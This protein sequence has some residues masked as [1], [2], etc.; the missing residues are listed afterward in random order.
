MGYIFWL[1]VSIIFYI[2]IGYP[3]VL[4]MANLT[5]QITKK[6]NI[7]PHVTLFIPAHNEQKVI[8]EKIE[9]SLALDYPKDKFEV[10]VASDGSGDSTASI[11]KDFIERGVILFETKERRGKNSIINEFIR[12][13][14]GEIIVFTDANSFFRADAIK[15][16]VRNFGDKGTGCVV[17]NLR[18]VD[19]KTSVGQ[20]EGLYF[21]YE[22][23]IK[24]LESHFGT[25][26]AATGSIYAIRKTLFTLL[27]WD[28]ANDFAHPIQIASMGYKV[29]FE[30][31]A[32]AY[33]KA[34]A[35]AADEFKRRARI[36]T[37]GITA[38]VRYCWSYHMLRGM[39]GFCFISHKLLRWFIPFILIT[40]FLSNIFLHS[41]FFR[42]ALYGQFVFYSIALFGILLKRRLGKLFVVPYYFCVINAAAFVGILK[43]LSGKRESIWEV[44]K[45]TR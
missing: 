7:T 15:N 4:R 14:H 36:V 31:D 17:G 5:G 1:F 20:G 25:L 33:E 18:Y 44:A 12:R 13:C 22:S 40:I 6:E 43:Y 2:Y 11:A 38:F 42:F 45:T 24:E 3:L 9:N 32:I 30:P 39:W 21:R 16:L 26:V 27:D 37:R 10:V 23:M 8:R 34:T 29:L 41:P 35:S 28:V 19:G